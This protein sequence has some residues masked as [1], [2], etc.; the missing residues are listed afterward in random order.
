MNEMIAAKDVHFRYTPENPY[1]VD[2]ASMT[3]RKGE[4]VAVLCKRLRQ[5]HPGQAF[6]RHPAAGERHRDGG[7]HGYPG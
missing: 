6:Q 1:A 2:G 5:V 7:G 3:I 4:F